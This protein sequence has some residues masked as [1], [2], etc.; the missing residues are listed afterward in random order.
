LIGN[1][2]DQRQTGK[3]SL[4]DESSVWRD[5]HPAAVSGHSTLIE[6]Q[7]VDGDGPGRFQWIHEES[8]DLHEGPLI[9]HRDPAPFPAT[10]P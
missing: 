4:G 6:R 2:C 7:T 10:A 8:A 3:G 9:S 1:G 5:D